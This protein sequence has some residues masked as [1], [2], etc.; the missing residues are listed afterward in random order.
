MK[1]KI[2]TMLAISAVAFTSCKK[3]D[4]A[5]PADPGTC[6]VMGTVQAAQDLSN[7]TSATGAYSYNLNPEDV[8]GVKMTFVIDSEDLD[9]NP[10]PSYDYQDLTYSVDV[11]NG[12]Y[13]ID[14]P[15][16]STPLTVDVYFDDYNYS[17]VQ[18]VATNPDTIP[19]VTTSYEFFL[20]PMSIGN[21]TDGSTV[22]QNFMYNW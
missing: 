22:V 7:D 9:H 2:F 8:S 21:I 20:N 18:Y 5:T 1:R 14:L 4:P 6:T 17:Q 13:S 10:D 15:A 11:T 19:Q 12:T 16:I 3:E